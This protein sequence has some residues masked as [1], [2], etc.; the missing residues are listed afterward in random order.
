FEPPLSLKIEFNHS[1]MADQAQLMPYTKRLDGRTIEYQT[2]DYA[3]LF[4]A[5]M[6]LVYLAQ[7]TP[8]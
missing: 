4:E 6:V 8:M 3:I 7:T 2:D 5:I 1:S